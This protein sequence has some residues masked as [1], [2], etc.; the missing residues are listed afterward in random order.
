MREDVI[1][2]R[3]LSRLESLGRDDLAASLRS[4]HYTIEQFAGCAIN[5]D[6]SGM[7]VELQRLNVSISELLRIIQHR[8]AV[9]VDPP[10]R[11]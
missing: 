5:D 2:T 6:L 7:V 1:F 8:P 11:T 4:A 3:N 10:E 9:S